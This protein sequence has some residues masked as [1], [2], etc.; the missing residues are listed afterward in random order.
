[1]ALA[2]TK[3]FGLNSFTFEL[4][5]TILMLAAEVCA[6]QGA[7]DLADYPLQRTKATFAAPV[8]IGLSL[9]VAELSGLYWTGGALNPARAFGP[10]V[11]FLELTGSIVCLSNSCGLTHIHSYFPRDWPVTRGSTCSRFLQTAESS[12]L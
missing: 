8:G 4:S 2:S 5:F 7:L 3:D 10:A 6:Y 12:E 11:H 9:F 1:M